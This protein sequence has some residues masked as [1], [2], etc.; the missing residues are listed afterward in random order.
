MPANIFSSNHAIKAVTIS[1]YKFS[2][3]IFKLANSEA[4]RSKSKMA[5]NYA[6][7]NKNNSVVAPFPPCMM[8]KC[9]Y[10]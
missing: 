2:G 3:T 9:A 10:I 6:Q 5:A 4:N 8:T 1:T 7:P